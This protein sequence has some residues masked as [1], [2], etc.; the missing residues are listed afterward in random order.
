MDVI[1]HHYSGVEMNPVI[2]FTETMFENQVAGVLGQRDSGSG[3][4]SDEERGIVFLQMRESAAIAVFGGGG[5]GINY[6]G[7]APSPAN[8]DSLNS[9]ELLVCDA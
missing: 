7:R 2:V 3:A 6:V 5:L 9:P 1:G 4:E 8:A